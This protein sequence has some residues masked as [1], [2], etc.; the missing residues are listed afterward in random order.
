MFGENT[1]TVMATNAGVSDKDYLSMENVILKS[2]CESECA[3]CLGFVKC[4]YKRLNVCEHF[5]FL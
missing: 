2:V 5:P 3:M 1:I 4:K